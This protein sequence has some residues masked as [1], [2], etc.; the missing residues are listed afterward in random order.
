MTKAV[1]FARVSSDKPED[2]NSLDGQTNNMKTYCA[3]KNFEIIKEIK[4][5]ESSTRGERE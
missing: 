5:V 4:L 1:I 2:N 3:K